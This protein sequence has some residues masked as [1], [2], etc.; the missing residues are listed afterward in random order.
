MFNKTW[1]KNLDQNFNNIYN[2][3]AKIQASQLNKKETKIE[4]NS[5]KTERVEID[6]N[7]PLKACH[8]LPSIGYSTHTSRAVLF[9][10][11][12]DRWLITMKS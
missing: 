2:V 11:K 8:R 9:R 5:N 1:T 4:R 3:P 10:G 7:F 6:H 12:N